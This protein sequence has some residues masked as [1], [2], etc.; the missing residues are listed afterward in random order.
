MQ[1]V[2]ELEYIEERTIEIYENMLRESNKLYKQ[3][4]T[5]RIKNLLMDMMLFV[6]YFAVTGAVIL[7]ATTLGIGLK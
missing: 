5:K 2:E 3:E 4:K 7:W 1:Q 6:L